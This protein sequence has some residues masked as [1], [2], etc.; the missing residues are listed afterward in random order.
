MANKIYMVAD[1]EN[2][3]TNPSKTYAAGFKVLGENVLHIQNNLDDF[4]KE[5]IEYGNCNV[6]FHN[7]TYDGSFVIDWLLKHGYKYTQLT[8]SG[9]IPKE[10]VKS[11]G[12]IIDGSLTIY[13]IVIRTEK[14]IIQM[15]DTFRIVTGSLEEIG[16]A[17]NCKTKKLSGT[18]DYDDPKFSSDDYNI[19]N[20]EITLKYFQHDLELTAEILE[21]IIE[22]GFSKKLT[23]ASNALERFKDIFYNKPNEVGSKYYKKNRDEHFRLFFPE[24]CKQE[25]NSVRQAYRG[26][27]CY[28]NTDSLPYANARGAIKGEYHKMEMGY[29]YDVN[30]LYPSVMLS[31]Y[32]YPIGHGKWISGNELKVDKNKFYVYHL[33]VTFTLKENHLPFIQ[34]KNSMSFL[35]NEFVKSGVCEDIWLC[36]PDYELFHEQYDIE[37]ED[38]IGV[39]EYSAVTGLFDSYVMTMYEGKKN[40]KGAKRQ[41]YK[42]LLNSLYGRFGMRIENYSAEPYISDEDNAVHYNLVKEECE[43]VYIPVAVAVTAY[44]RGVTVRAAQANYDNFLYSDTDSIHLSKPAVGIDV[45]PSKIG[46]WDNEDTFTKARYIRQKTYIELCNKGDK[47]KWTVKACGLPKQAKNY[48]IAT[49][50]KDI[51]NQFQKGLVI[52]DKKLRRQRVEGGTILTLTDFSIR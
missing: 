42:Y 4:F 36:T 16:E 8:K 12:G 11:F 52:S 31:P 32:K 40:S 27:W 47:K 39:Y 25:D 13:K 41:F 30:S 43:G 49:A 38:I 37:Y 28:N 3:N 5:L 21:I 23:I 34:I 15:K 1:T 18:V 14:G 2:T 45:D 35:P 7:L 22:E 44:G 46:A 26:G 48:F 6:W 29:V 10:A 24:L 17:F 33:N 19:F 20:D 9:S 50:K 51:I